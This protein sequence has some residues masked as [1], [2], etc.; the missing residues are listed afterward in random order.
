MRYGLKEAKKK[1]AEAA[2]AEEHPAAE[3]KPSKKAKK[4]AAAPPA[5]ATALT[6]AQPAKPAFATP[7][8]ALVALTS[9]RAFASGMD[10]V[11]EMLEWVRLPQYADAFDANGWDDV[12]FLA[13]LEPEVLQTTMSQVADEVGMKSGHKQK[14]CKLLPAYLRGE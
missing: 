9:P 12:E 13:E 7:S 6:P 11:R 5:P 2:E 8:T 10:G 1:R 14:L 3:E 4:A